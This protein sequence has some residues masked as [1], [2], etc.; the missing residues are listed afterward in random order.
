M[1]ILPDGHESSGYIYTRN[2]KYET[3]KNELWCTGPTMITNPLN[4][5]N[6]DGN[7]R[8]TVNESSSDMN[9][10]T[11]HTIIKTSKME[12]IHVGIHKITKIENYSSLK[13]LFRVS[14]Y[15]LRFINNRRSIRNVRDCLVINLT[16]EK[17]KQI[18]LHERCWMLSL[19][20]K[21]ST[22]TEMGECY[23]TSIRL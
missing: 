20:Q 1:E 16:Q 2:Y 12:V 18:P 6:W 22:P 8:G 4:G 17:C 3:R 11:N 19:S 21:W 23:Q 14:V 10:I 13:R 9:M 15:V 5:P 7:Q